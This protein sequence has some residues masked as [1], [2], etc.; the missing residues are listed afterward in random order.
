MDKRKVTK[1]IATSIDDVC[2]MYGF[3]AVAH[4]GTY[5]HYRRGGDVCLE[6]GIELH[7]ISGWSSSPGKYRVD[8]ALNSLS[9][10]YSHYVPFCSPPG[11]LTIFRL[12]GDEHDAFSKMI[13]G[14]C[15][16]GYDVD[17]GVGDVL[18]CIAYGVELYPGFVSF[19]E[20]FAYLKG[21]QYLSYAD[22]VRRLSHA[23][24]P[25][26]SALPDYPGIGLASFGTGSLCWLGHLLCLSKYLGDQLSENLDYAEAILNSPMP[27]IDG[28]SDEWNLQ[29]VEREGEFR[30]RFSELFM[31]ALR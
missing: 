14:V 16:V 15:I 6:L 4:R 12:D 28:F 20:L 22:I 25:Y 11:K 17:C 18:K 19:E 30:K 13:N 23:K 10:K 3:S 31:P 9:T 2:R 5:I 1:L 26:W 27:Y 29:L 21:F 24:T 7:S 8:L